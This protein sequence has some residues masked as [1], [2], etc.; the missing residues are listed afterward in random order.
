MLEILIIVKF[1]QN[2]HAWMRAYR[3]YYFNTGILSLAID[4]QLNRL[5]WHN[6]LKWSIDP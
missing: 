4:L 1:C 3:K 6:C 2:E 5:S